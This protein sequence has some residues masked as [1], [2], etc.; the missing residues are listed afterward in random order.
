M[1][2]S[3]KIEQKWEYAENF[4]VTEVQTCKLSNSPDMNEKPFY[5]SFVFIPE[6]LGTDKRGVLLLT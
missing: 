4:V 3:V 6:S 1:S 5:R 2:L